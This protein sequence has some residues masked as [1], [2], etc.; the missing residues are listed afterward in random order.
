MLTATRSS[1]VLRPRLLLQRT[2]AR[3]GYA[4]YA[5]A[6]YRAMAWATD[7]Q[8]EAWK[9]ADETL[10]ARMATYVPAALQHNGEE[11]MCLLPDPHTLPPPPSSK[12]E[13][14]KC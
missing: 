11:G 10:H 2:A 13:K 9:T 1:R 6:P 4:D 8:L 14:K 5:V 7:E 3:R 12:R